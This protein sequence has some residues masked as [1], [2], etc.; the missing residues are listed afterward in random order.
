MVGSEDP[1]TLAL[2]FVK[3]LNQVTEYNVTEIV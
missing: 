2:L 1:A 3:Y